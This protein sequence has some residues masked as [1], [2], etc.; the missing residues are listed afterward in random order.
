MD[1]R[2]ISFEQFRDKLIADNSNLPAKLEYGGRY[3]FVTPDDRTFE[4]WLMSIE[5]KYTPRLVDL[6]EPVQDFTALPL[7]SGEF[8]RAPNGHDGLIEIRHPG[9]E[10]SPLVLD[11]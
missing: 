9:C 1:A 10:Q 4:I 3:M 7:V 8:M 6:F 5:Q 11:F 2:Q